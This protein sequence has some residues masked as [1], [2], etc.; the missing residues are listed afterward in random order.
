METKRVYY[1]FCDECGA[2][3]ASYERY[4]SC[5]YCHGNKRKF[6][7]IGEAD[8]TFDAEIAVVLEQNRERW[9]ASHPAHGRKTR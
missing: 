3:T 1:Y 2:D 4:R 6:R 8:S 5:P 7:L 9:D